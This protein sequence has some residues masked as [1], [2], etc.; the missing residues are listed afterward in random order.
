GTRYES[1]NSTPGWTCSGS[2][3]TF[4]IGSLASGAIH[5]ALLTLRADAPPVPAGRNVL[6]NRADVTD[7]GSQSRG[8][9]RTAS[10]MESTPLLA[11]PDLA[12]VK[13]DGGATIHPGELLTYT[14]TLSNVGDQH[15][16]GTH[17]E[18]T[19]PFHTTFVPGASSPGW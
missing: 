11:A 12:L 7:D 4:E 13:D 3:C 10:A 5:H 18:E 17:I 1:T 14:L 15:A 9:P 6:V 16:T 2:Q 8:E 19:V